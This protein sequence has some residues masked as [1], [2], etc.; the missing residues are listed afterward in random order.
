MPRWPE[1]RRWSKLASIRLDLETA[2]RR[3]GRIVVGDQDHGLAWEGLERALREL[4]GVRELTEA[5]RG[6]LTRPLEG[7]ERSQRR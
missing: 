2:V 5:E 4:E 6:F 3:A 7:D 1:R